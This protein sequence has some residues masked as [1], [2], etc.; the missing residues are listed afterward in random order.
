MEID[1]RIGEVA[2]RQHA[3]VTVEQ[4]RQLGAGKKAVRHRVHRGTL[5]P[6]RRGVYVLT[7]VRPTSE[8]AVLAA[9]LASG[10]NAF[11]SHL[12]AADLWGLPAPPPDR[13]EITSVLEHHVR[14]PGVRA[15][16]SG[17]LHEHDV[18]VV[19]MVPSTTA[20]RLVV[21]L[22]TRLTTDELGALLD[23]AMRR[24]LTS[25][26]RVTACVARLGRA[27]GRSP[28]RL[29]QVLARRIPGYDPGDSDLE[30]YVWRVLLE[31]GLPAARRLHRVEIGGRTFKIDLAYPDRKIAIEVD[32]FD[33]HR[34]RTEFDAD[35]ERQNA[36]IGAGWSVLRFT[37]RST[38]PTIVSAVLP[39][40]VHEGAP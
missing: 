16:R 34:T 10:P 9:V 8:R 23:E 37:S 14:I 35:R 12:T 33:F 6:V 36:L 29:A 39:L 24:R 25:L 13:I 26:S 1:A 15:H 11:A 5:R 7:G 3:L 31:A 30:T 32:G 2:E 19:R 28:K 17:L 40:F 20:T 38:P 22:S 21:D 18:T 27:P 4:L